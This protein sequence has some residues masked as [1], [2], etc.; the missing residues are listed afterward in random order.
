[1]SDTGTYNAVY[2]IVR[3]VAITV[4]IVVADSIGAGYLE[5][6]RQE[7]NHGMREYKQN[8]ISLAVVNSG[9][10]APKLDSSDFSVTGLE[11]EQIEALALESGSEA[12]LRES[13][14]DG[15]EYF[16]T[17]TARDEC[18]WG[19]PIDDSGYRL[20]FI[21]LDKDKQLSDRIQFI[22]VEGLG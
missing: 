21:Y 10:D 11:Q 5:A 13:F 22:R 12:C 7:I 15:E 19:T 14:M 2:W 20:G 17:T 4:I 1:M 6:T 3:L 16:I 18:N 9:A 8:A